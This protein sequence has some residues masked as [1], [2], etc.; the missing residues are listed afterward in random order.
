MVVGRE[1]FL[2]RRKESSGG[3]VIFQC[4]SCVTIDCTINPFDAELNPICHLLTLL[5]AHHIL[6]VSRVR[7]NLNERSRFIRLFGTAEGSVKVKR[8]LK[9][10]QQTESSGEQMYV[11]RSKTEVFQ[12]LQ[13]EI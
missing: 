11:F 6:H 13:A 10:S 12:L 7:V 3:E 9:Q 4:V 8:Y 2:N 1:I 5:G